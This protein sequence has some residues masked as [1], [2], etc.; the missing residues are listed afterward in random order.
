M[1][2]SLE[3]SDS[4]A[5]SPEDDELALDTLSATRRVFT[6]QK[7]VLYAVHVKQF[8][9]K[10]KGKANQDYFGPKGP[11]YNYLISS[12]FWIFMG[13][14]IVFGS[15]FYYGEW[16][17]VQHY[18][19]VVYGGSIA[20][21]AN[22]AIWLD[23][24][25]DEKYGWKTFQ[26]NFETICGHDG[27]TVWFAIFIMC[28]IVWWLTSS[29]RG[30]SISPVNTETADYIIYISF[31]AAC[32]FFLFAFLASWE[33][34]SYYASTSEWIQSFL[35]LTIIGGIAL[36][37]ARWLRPPSDN[38][39]THS[40]HK[41]NDVSSYVSGLFIVMNL[42]FL[43]SITVGILVP[44]AAEVSSWASEQGMFTA[45]LLFTI[46]A[47]TMLLH[48]LAPGTGIDV[49][50][51]FFFTFVFTNKYNLQFIE[52]YLLT[53]VILILFHY[54]GACIQWYLGK[55][56]FI[57][58][59]LNSMLPTVLLASSDATLVN[60]SWFEVG[61]IGFFWLDTL[62][63]FNQGRINM[64]FWTQLMSEWTCLPNAFCFGAF[65]AAIAAQGLEALS[66]H[67]WTQTAIPLFIIAGS[68]FSYA[69]LF[70][71]LTVMGSKMSNK[72]FWNSR[73]KWE[74]KRYWE[75]KG[76]AATKLGWSE[77]DI[78][79]LRSLGDSWNDDEDKGLF[80]KIY[81]HQ[82]QFVIESELAKSQKDK[83][84]F[85]DAF[86]QKCHDIRQAH[87]DEMEQHLETYLE[88]G[89]MTK[90]LAKT[91]PKT[92]WDD[93]ETNKCKRKWQIGIVFTLILSFWVMISGLFLGIEIDVAV[94]KKSAA[95][96]EVSPFTWFGLGWFFIVYNVYWFQATWHDL[97]GMWSSVV[98]L[99]SGCPMANDSM[100]TTFGTPEWTVPPEFERKHLQKVKEKFGADAFLIDEVDNKENAGIIT[101]IGASK[102][103]RKKTKEA[104]SSSDN[105]D[106]D[107]KVEVRSSNP[108]F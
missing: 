37:N 50:G 69:G 38:E 32:I 31:Y 105:I 20:L 42:G 108:T 1:A 34:M 58:I 5:K 104:Y 106:K 45:C 54:T 95:L 15:V 63:G 90:I 103:S 44:L 30:E 89:Y 96:K 71:A 66:S 67:S 55:M 102:M 72:I 43:G 14:T 98:Y 75:R 60:A 62:N 11:W 80:A 10:H 6:R 82:L 65:G 88:E 51:G 79:Q 83:L 25:D 29:V 87:W 76:Y 70:W 4:N 26:V 9:D 93:V 41:R 84:E 24:R 57:Q 73:E 47:F 64:A 92:M 85:V 49:L 2:S 77:I 107:E 23:F 99:C 16:N 56:P 13:A 17:D 48:P 81:P 35:Y 21:L 46:V 53:V 97:K 36:E 19:F 12:L 40:W 78:F 52:T 86:E 59:W 39:H 28:S 101:A 91:K 22:I 61:I 74:S 94:K 3:M 8:A 68:G 18:D 33:L 27:K 7:S 100:E